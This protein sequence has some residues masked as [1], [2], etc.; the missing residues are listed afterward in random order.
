M[1]AAVLALHPVMQSFAQE[2][3]RAPV[4]GAPLV[5]IDECRN[6]QDATV[7]AKITEV[8]ETG[9]KTELAGVNYSALVDTY[10]ANAKVGERI[11]REV[12]AAV[13]A[14]RADSSWL[15]RA[16][17][18]VSQAT[19]E[20]FATAVA[21]RAY[22][23]A[24]FRAAIED[25]ATG[26]GREIG[27]RLEEVTSRIA[28][29]VVACVQTA[30]QSR[31]GMAI[32]DVFARESQRTL[33]V[34][35]EE[36]RAKINPSDLVLTNVASISGIVLIV[37]RRVIGRMVAS[38][39]TRIAGAVAARIVASITGIIGLALIAKDIYDAG[40]G[41]FPI[42][43]ERMKS[44]DTKALIRAEIAKSIETE[45]TEQLG[46][47]ARET[48]ERIYAI[49][50]DF[51]QRY[52]RLLGLAEANESFAAFLKDRRLDQIDRLG[53]LVDIITGTEGRD[54][55][56]KR[57]S[58]GSLNRALLNLTDA[59]VQ[60]ASDRKSIEDGLRWTQL[61]GNDLPRVVD[62]GLHRII[63]PGDITPDALRKLL[64]LPDRGAITRLA[65]LDPGARE[66]ILSLPVAQVRD[67]TRQLNE[68]QLAAFA[69]YRNRLDPAAARRLLQAV[70][71]NPRVMLD[72]TSPGL[73]ESV[74]NSRNQLA[75]LEMLIR[76]DE[77]LVSYGRILNDIQ[78]VR[79]GAVQPRVF[80]ARYWI[81]VGVAAVIALILLLWLK[82]LIFGRPTT[83]V[84]RENGSKSR[85]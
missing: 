76:G 71:E 43:G 77:W 62:L 18:N 60:V 9:L 67:F 58:D 44:E 39:G 68:R 41:V 15:D 61:A 74:L 38:L 84:I 50:L 56:F 70:T 23:S 63:A 16:Y 19:A 35:A 65:Q 6:L 72:L 28:S 14:V 3:T 83:V 27:S 52:E 48:S 13:A 5:T 31:Y 54:G 53:Q 78:L 17:S 22:N 57:V 4:Q 36:G 55:V 46:A 34:T 29:P 8:A 25:V 49:W 21:D 64:A 82:R 40:E 85:R 10:W 59:G 81:S 79:D 73:A 12:D 30:L 26:I 1:S 7:R 32:S 47:I 42:I 75:A 51:R 20:R 66:A 37:T 69:D 24:E 33:D 80:I 2:V 11:D 45:V